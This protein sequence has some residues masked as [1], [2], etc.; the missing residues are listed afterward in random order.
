MS[1]PVRF[2]AWMPAMRA[3]PSTS[4]FGASPAATVAAVAGAMRTTARATAR[5]ALTG[6]PL[7]STMRARPCSS[8][9]VR[10]LTGSRRDGR[11]ARGGDQVAH[12]L[13]VAGPQEGDRVGL[14]VDDALEER[15]A[16]LVGGQRALR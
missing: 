11:G 12:A 15:L 14:A 9:W 2:A 10:P 6:L 16:V 4:P 3:V 5:R 1:S 8:R 13:H 7:T